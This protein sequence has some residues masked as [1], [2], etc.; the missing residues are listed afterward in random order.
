MSSYLGIDNGVT[1]GLAFLEQGYPPQVLAMPVQET[2]KGREVDIVAVKRVV[3][4][5]METLVTD[6]TVVI[7]EP[8]GS[9]NA[10]AASSMAGSF[11]ALRAMV[12]IMGLKLVRITPAQW[13]K[14]M[15]KCKKKEETKPVA[16]QLARSLWPK[17]DLRSNER[18]RVA[19]D[20]IVDALLIAEFARRHQL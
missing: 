6:L 13:Q 2:R 5:W 17:L 18:C 12:E 16:L 7:E 4:V 20:G 8:G 10:K 9:Q 1:G 11:H 3:D 19:N 14:P 15:L